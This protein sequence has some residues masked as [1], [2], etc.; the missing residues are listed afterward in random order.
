M[1]S[2]F[3]SM[4]DSSDTW[5]V[6][7]GTVRM[8]MK[9]RAPPMR[10]M[11]GT[12]TTS[13]FTTGRFSNP[14]LTKFSIPWPKL[15]LWPSLM[16]G[17]MVTRWAPCTSAFFTST[18][19]PMETPRFRRT[20]PSTRTMPFPSSSCM[21][22]KS[23][24]AVVFF[25]TSSMISP[26]STP[27]AMRVRVSTRAR[28]SPTSDCGASATLRMTRSG[29]VLKYRGTLF[30]HLGARADPDNQSS[31]PPSAWAATA[32]ASVR[33]PRATRSASSL[34]IVRRPPER[35]RLCR[36]ISRSSPR[37]G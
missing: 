8:T 22:R 31:S 37:V 35:I 3:I 24:A 11:P 21:V 28:P 15:T 13:P 33:S 34:E 27:R 16:M 36:W 12:M 17:A 9:G 26:T 6:P 23:F 30:Y 2:S 20:R 14:L 29:I 19:S 18:L 10:A 4:R 32:S 5:T 25:P 1:G 7:R